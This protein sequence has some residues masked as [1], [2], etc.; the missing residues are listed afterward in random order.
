MPLTLCEPFQWYLVARCKQCGVRQPTYRDFSDGKS[1]LLRNYTWRCIQCE[2]IAVYEPT[3]IDAISTM[4]RVERNRE[5][6]RWH[7]IEES[8]YLIIK[9]AGE[10]LSDHNSLF[11]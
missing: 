11:K 4:W 7:D 1:A 8:H 10:S 5:R 3:E 9:L 6:E 2:H